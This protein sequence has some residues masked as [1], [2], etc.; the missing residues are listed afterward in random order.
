MS[1]KQPKRPHLLKDGEP[2]TWGDNH[3]DGGAGLV[4]CFVLEDLKISE[5]FC[6]A[7]TFTQMMLRVTGVKSL[8]VCR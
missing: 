2:I 8:P 4:F 6:D 1:K 5:W 7:N 3:H